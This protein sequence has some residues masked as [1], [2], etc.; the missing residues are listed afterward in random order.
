M[1]HQLLPP[2]AILPCLLLLFLLLIW[3]AM[4]MSSSE[5]STLAMVS[6]LAGPTPTCPAPPAGCPQSR[7]YGYQPQ[8]YEM[9]PTFNKAANNTL[10]NGG[11]TYS[12]IN[13]FLPPNTI[14]ENVSD[15]RP[16]PHI[17][18]R[19]VAWQEAHWL[20][21]ANSVGDSDNTY[22]CTLVSSDC[23]YGLMQITSCMN[24]GCGW[25]MPIRASGELTYNLG[26]GTNFLIQ[27]WNAAPF[28]GD[29]D[30]TSAEQWYY[31]VTAY[32]G[33]SSSNDPNNSTLDPRRPP[34]GEGSYANF[35]YPYQERVWGLMAHPE[36]AQA[37][38][39][40][41]W[42]P[43]RVAAVPRGIFG[44]G[45]GW[46]PPSRTPKPVFHLLQGIQVAG[47]TG[48]SIVLRNVTTQTLAVDIVFYN[49]DHTFNRRWLDSSSNPPWYR[50]PYI[51]LNANS[52]RAL[53][54]ANIFPGENFAGY[55]RI[56]ASEGIEIA[57]RP[58][59]YSNKVFLPLVLNNHGGNCSERVYDG[60]FELFSNGRPSW[61]VI[62]ADS[63]PLADGTWF[64]SGHYGAYLGGY[65]YADDQLYRM[66]DIPSNALSAR[67][68]LSWYMQSQEPV[69]Y[70][71]Y[72][73][74]F[75]RLRDLLSGNLI[76]TL[77]T[78]SNRSTR[79]AWQTLT[80]DLQ[81]YAGRSMRLSF[82]AD[83]DLSNPTSF[84]I[85]NVSLRV[86]FP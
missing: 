17:I 46:Q 14:Q 57:L 34:Y 19:G 29:N 45:S 11:P 1:N 26:T 58:P 4:A 22:A 65:D 50:W 70:G 16:I 18:L 39:R 77:G 76:A 47:G 41:L 49:T 2:R 43:V 79:G 30:H 69:Y 5:Y 86:C 52:S 64:R 9:R 54:V 23:G 60:G 15:W 67:L 8:R 84:F 42:R 82:E 13:R 32:N 10:G 40:W 85:D 48:P 24:N 56:S 37:G 53:A 20:Q 6:P 83:N 74:L 27:K 62:S 71:E 35:S 78:L 7:V 44:L 72:D 75:I 33:W 12:Q 80:F 59:S 61:S 68:T 66:I 81:P 38:S 3:A 28:V 55:A 51:R 63:Y 21:F 36:M 25:F 31:A 73:F